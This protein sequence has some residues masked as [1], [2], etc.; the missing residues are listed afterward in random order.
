MI[1]MPLPMTMIGWDIENMHPGWKWER[2]DREKGLS[3]GV[4]PNRRREE[5]DTKRLQL[6]LHPRRLQPEGNLTFAGWL[7]PTLTNSVTAKAR[8]MSQ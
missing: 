8:T 3:N 7:L 4:K 6:R 2:Q 5:N 1:T